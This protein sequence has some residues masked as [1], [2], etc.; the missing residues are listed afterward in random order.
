MKKRIVVALM[1]SLGLAGSA[2]ADGLGSALS[3]VAQGQ[4]MQAGG[5]PILRGSELGGILGEWGMHPENGGELRRMFQ[6][7]INPDSCD[8]G[9]INGWLMGSDMLSID[10][11]PRRGLWGLIIPIHQDGRVM[12]GW[13]EQGTLFPNPDMA[14]LGIPHS[15][16]MAVRVAPMPGRLPM[17][18]DIQQNAASYVPDEKWGGGIGCY[19]Y[20]TIE[21]VSYACHAVGVNAMRKLN[22]A[23]ATEAGQVMTKPMTGEWSLGLGMGKAHVEAVESGYKTLMA[24]IDDTWGESAPRYVFLC[25]SGASS[26]GVGH[27]PLKR[28]RAWG[29]KVWEPFQSEFHPYLFHDVH[30]VFVKE[31]L[32]QNLMTRDNDNPIDALSRSVSGMEKVR[33]VAVPFGKVQ[34]TLFGF[35]SGAAMPEDY[36]L[37]AIPESV[38]EK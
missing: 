20:Q 36:W 33:V 5:A 26:T 37:A 24:N 23:M 32:R 16:G 9:L 35:S 1:L 11:G 30:A 13:T 14:K 3:G 4:G 25:E 6:N 21:H 38:K 28:W 22:E 15:F 34:N 31:N 7:G 10:T 12:D 29:E 18:S 19:G 27:V 2:L 8:V 17:W